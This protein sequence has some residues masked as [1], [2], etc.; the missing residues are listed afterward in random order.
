M[1]SSQ[2]CLTGFLLAFKVTGISASPVFKEGDWTLLAYSDEPAPKGALVCIHTRDGL[3][4]CDQPL[5]D[6]HRGVSGRIA[7]FISHG[8]PFL[9]KRKVCK[10]VYASIG[11]Y[12]PRRLFIP[13]GEVLAEY[14]VVAALRGA[15]ELEV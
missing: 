10:N 13:P 3:Y 7:G 15:I 6:K 8:S 5:L 2:S 12:G 11:P 1:I 4:G 14:P 9:L